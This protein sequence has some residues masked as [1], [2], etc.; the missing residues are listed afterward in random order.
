VLEFCHFSPFGGYY[1]TQRTSRKVLD[2]GLY[3]PTIFKD[4]WRVYENCD[5][6]QRATISITRKDEMPQQPVLYCEIFNIWGIDFMGPFPP[7]FG[8]TFIFPIVDYV[9]KWVE[10]MATRTNDARVVMSFVKSNIFCRF[11]IPRA[12]INDQRTHFF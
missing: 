7:S 10:A 2:F 4:A 3:W 5:Q 9:S 11:R 12:I 6:Y 1:G 8:F